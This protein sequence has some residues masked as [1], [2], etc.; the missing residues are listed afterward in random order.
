[1][2]I[3][4]PTADL[5]CELSEDKI[6]S[7]VIENQHLFCNMITDIQS[8]LDGNDGEFVLSE[9]Y[10][11]LDMRKNTDLISQLVPFTVNQK[12]LITKLYSLLKKEAVNA[13][14]YQTTYDILSQI[15]KYIYKLT[16]EQEMELTMTVPEDVAG[17]LKAF[18]VRFDDKDL[19]LS[20]KLLEYMIT[21]SELKGTKVF[22]TVN[23]RSYLTDNQS[24]QLFQSLVL[25]KITLIC[26]ESS[27]HEKFDCEKVV[28]IDKDMCI[29]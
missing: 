25:R 6:L 20:E 9:N 12:D 16:E 26:I 28:V 13:E 14:Y 19:T 1:M 23:L 17:I 3:A 21:A 7:L 22:F 4:Y 15:S 11:P 24:E 8:Q 18:D 5:C 10:Q 29:I 27:V 2:M